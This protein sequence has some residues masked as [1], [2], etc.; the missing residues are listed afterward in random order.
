MNSNF[1]IHIQ[2]NKV[3]ERAEKKLKEMK[4]NKKDKRA[5]SSSIVKPV[6]V[7]KDDPIV[8]RMLGQL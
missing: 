2:S 7:G 6:R 4:A 8:K 5:S 1:Q 3:K